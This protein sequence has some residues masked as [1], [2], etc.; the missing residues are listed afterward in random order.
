MSRFTEGVTRDLEQIADSASPSPAAWDAIKARIDS[1]DE[2]PTTEVT[3]LTPAG[4]RT[5]RPAWGRPLTIAAAAAVV[6]LIVGLATLAGGGTNFDGN[7]VTTDHETTDTPELT[8]DPEVTDDE[9]TAED[10][11]P[12]E[13]ATTE[14]VADLPTWTAFTTADGLASNDVIAI[15]VH[16]DGTTWAMTTNPDDLDPFLTGISLSR[17]DNDGW[18]TFDVP[19]QL[20]SGPLTLGIVDLTDG[21]A[22]G[23]DGT[24]WYLGAGLWEFDGEVWTTV[25][26]CDSMTCADIPGSALDVGGDGVLWSAHF[27]TLLRRDGDAWTEIEPPANTDMFVPWTGFDSPRFG[28]EVDGDGVVWVFTVDGVASYDGEWHNHPV[29]SGTHYGGQGLNGAA[30]WILGADGV[31]TTMTLGYTDFT[32]N[33]GPIVTSI[34]TFDEEGWA[35]SDGLFELASGQAPPTSGPDIHLATSRGRHLFVSAAVCCDPWSNILGGL[36]WTDM[37]AGTTQT[38][39]VEDGLP[40]DKIQALTGSPD[41]SVWIATDA[42]IARFV[43]DSE[44]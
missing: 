42:G 11:T 15:D 39:T 10:S 18:T 13:D 30:W 43:P 17:F 38:L 2:Q 24:A 29:P 20:A 32:E 7:V 40:S 28:Y 1:A 19:E 27:E 22:A 33:G 35:S 44:G 6:L 31:S 36:I 14:P 4:A 41:G 21:L 5:A 12:T 16:A 3:V 23:P 34:S 8:E 26:E 9:G 37:D 25:H